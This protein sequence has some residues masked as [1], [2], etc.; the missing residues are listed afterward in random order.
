MTENYSDEMDRATALSALILES[1]IAAV[2]SA[3]GVRLPAIGV[4]H[5]CDAPVDGGRLFCDGECAADYE[6][7]RAARVR[8]GI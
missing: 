8:N 3:V 4:C 6:K 1:Q 7:A 2:R 5:S